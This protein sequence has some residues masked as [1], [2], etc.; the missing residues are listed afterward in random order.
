MPTSVLVTFATRTGTTREAAETIAEVIK[1]SG[2]NAEICPL[3]VMHKLEQYQAV[4]IGAPLYMF[5]W[6]NDA[7]SFLSNNR[8]LLEKIPVA[9]FALGPVQTPRNEEEWAGA[10]DQLD[11]ALADFPWLTPVS[12]GLFGGKY[13]PSKLGFPMKLFAA[14]MPEMDARDIDAVRTWALDLVEKI[15]NR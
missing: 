3:R 9:V 10:H 4:V 15:K 5:R 13:D 8:S 7:R 11:K 14:Q 12:V 2:F 6:H 1:E